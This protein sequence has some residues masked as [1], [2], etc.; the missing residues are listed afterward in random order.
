[1]TDF[2]LHLS[3]IQAASQT[4]LQ[5]ADALNEQQRTF[6]QHI[7]NSSQTLLKQID[8]LPPTEAAYVQV[9]PALGD[10]FRN[11]QTSLVGYAQMLL[12]HPQQFGSETVSESQ[13]AQLQTIYT[14]AVQLYQAT[15]AITQAAFEQRQALRQQPAAAFD[16]VTML[17]QQ[18]PLY[19]YWL[20]T[21]PVRLNLGLDV[22]L[23]PAWGRP[24][25]LDGL[26]RHVLVTMA[27]ELVEYGE[28]QLNAVDGRQ[29]DKVTV[30]IFCTGTQ[31]RN[32]DLAV[33]FKDK[34]RQ[35]YLKHLQD[36]GGQITIE[37]QPGRGASLLV[38]LQT[39]ANAL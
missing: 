20:R 2:A 38:H 17:Y 30:A 15:E 39:A 3:A 21:Y 34:G 13:Q 16:L 14:H 9:I 19:H 25:H 22:M 24:Y 27:S 7:A 23:P 26:L 29:A 6:V 31:L 12:E 18:G 1:M 36:D 32:A 37:R 5:A 8:G 10:A 11:P 35:L 4:L 33:L 28:I